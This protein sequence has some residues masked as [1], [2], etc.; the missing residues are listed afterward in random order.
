M[1]EQGKVYMNKVNAQAFIEV[2]SKT[3][4]NIKELFDK[5]SKGLY[6]KY[7]TSLAFRQL[8]QPMSVPEFGK[9]QSFNLKNNFTGGKAER[10]LK[11]DKNCC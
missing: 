9:A 10:T 8:V 2:S 5:V 1:P 3:G 7:Q 6:K 11:K 4:E